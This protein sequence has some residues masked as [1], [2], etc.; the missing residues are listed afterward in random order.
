MM[1]IDS[2]SLLMRFP[3]RNFILRFFG[4]FFSVQQPR[5]G[6]GGGGDV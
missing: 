2:L 5:N 1:L 6:R 4:V 3:Y